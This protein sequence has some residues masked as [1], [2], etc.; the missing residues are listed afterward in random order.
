MLNFKYYV[1]IS[2][3]ISLALTVTCFSK[4]ITVNKKGS[5]GLQTI[6]EAL[7]IAGSG[8]L[9]KVGPGVYNENLIIDK[10]IFI[11]GSGPNFSTINSTINNVNENVY[12]NAV[13][14]TNTGIGIQITGFTIISNK[15]AVNVA[16]NVSNLLIK[17]CIL[18]GSDHGIYYFYTGY[19]TIHIIN[20]T[21]ID[22]RMSGIHWILSRGGA[23][24][25]IVNVYGNIIAY[26]G[27]YGINN[28]NILKCDY[29]NV[30]SNSSANYNG[31]TQGP[32]SISHNPSFIDHDA[33]NYVLSSKSLCINKGL[34]GI[35]YQDPDG[36][37]N[38]IGA[39]GGPESALFWP[40]PIEGP[41]VTNLFV[42]PASVPKGEKIKVQ[43]EGR[44]R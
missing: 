9:I 24:Q 23:T 8:D 35:S 44:I 37:R 34:I 14:I 38:D 22:N 13:N 36:S 11:H 41:I 2:V 39:Y 4:T 16:V 32:N 26:N 3:L 5:D 17:N 15:N 20:N 7:S 6:N 33:G 43:F 27:K 18:T 31:C 10:S 12:Y 1:L 19:S 25:S 28:S 30:F 21:I 42:T 29:N 40:Y